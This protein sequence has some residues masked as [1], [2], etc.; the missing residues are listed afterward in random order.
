MPG[1]GS[2]SSAHS[3]TLRDQAVGLDG[4]PYKTAGFE[5]IS[6]LLFW[7]AASE[8]VTVAVIAYATALSY[9]TLV[10]QVWPPTGTYVSAA[11]YIASLTMLVSLAFHHYPNLQTQPLHRFLWNGIGA[12]ALAFSFFL[13]TLFL[14]KVTEGYSR[15]TFFTQ[16][17]TVMLA[18]LALR[19]IGHARIQAALA[20]GRIE[21]RRAVVIGD[22]APQAKVSQRLKYAGVRIVGSLPFPSY[23]EITSAEEPDFD[24]KEARGLIDFC[25]AHKVDD[26]L[27]LATAANLRVS[28]RLGDVLS[29]L[30]VTLHMI[31]ADAEDLLSSAQLGGLGTLVTIQLLRPP[32]S[33]FDRVMK[34]FFDIAASA[35]GLLLLSPVLALVSLAIKLDSRGPVFFRQTRHGYNNEIIHVLKFR[36]MASNEDGY[37]FSQAKKDDP[38]VTRVGQTLRRTNLDELPQL[39]NVLT[40]EM[41]IVGPRPHPVALNTMFEEHISP[42]SRR[43]NMKPGITGWAQVNGYRG[44]T[45]TLEKMQRRFECDLFYIDNWS[46]L[47]DMKI[48]LMTLFSK[49]AYTNAF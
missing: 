37:A 44:E 18:V 41:S 10:L 4:A 24:R 26:V 20:S 1:N 40:G 25:R 29:E 23:A 38:R 48:I 12:V 21:A 43:H 47:L 11:L 5:N 32:L 28:A 49:T 6:V 9:S 16:L 19:T 8:F 17:L 46:F 34:R 22:P 2:V 15:G 7:I 33:S 36:S 30:P 35:T 42:F 27:I 45:D 31:P 39:L 13:S 14:L 3:S